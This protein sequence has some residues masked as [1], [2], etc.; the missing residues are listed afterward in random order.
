VNAEH[1]AAIKEQYEKALAME[2][3]F[4]PEHNY[5]V[6][7]KDPPDSKCGPDSQLDIPELSHEFPMWG[8]VMAKGPGYINIFKGV[9]LKSTG[10]NIGDRVMFAP[11]GGFELKVY[12]MTFHVFQHDVN[13]S[14]FFARVAVE[15]LNPETH[16][17][18]VDINVVAS[19]DKE[20]MYWQGNEDFIP[21]QL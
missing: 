19:N 9:D 18:D 13:S 20:Q 12:D 4:E 21:D 8:F 10:I 11:Y 14:D 6:I 1:K 17:P 2:H 5:V 7:L 3:S 16:L 15:K